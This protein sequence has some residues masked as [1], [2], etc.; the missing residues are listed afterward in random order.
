MIIDVQDTMT[1]HRDHQ[2][3]KIIGTINQIVQIKKN[4]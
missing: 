4:E 1:T 2:I 3:I